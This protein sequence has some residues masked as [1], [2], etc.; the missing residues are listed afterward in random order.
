MAKLTRFVAVGIGGGL[1]AYLFDPDRGKSRRARLRDQTMAR[2]RDI[3]AAMRRRTNYETGRV[4]GLVHELTV[5]DRPKIDDAGLC[6][7]IKSE[8]LGPAQLSDVEVDVENGIV[9]S[10]GTLRM[11]SIA[12]WPSRYPRFR[13]WNRSISARQRG[14]GKLEPGSA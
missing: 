3:R 4:K 14:L 2:L 10:P 1:I 13:E 7:R 5:N 6:Q 9:L 11:A 12:G 8:V